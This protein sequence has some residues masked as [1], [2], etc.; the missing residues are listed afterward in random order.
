MIRTKKPSTAVATIKLNDEE[1][2]VVSGGHPG[3]HKFLPPG[4]AKKLWHPTYPFGSRTQ[5]MTNTVTIEVNG[6][7][8]QVGVQITGTQ[9]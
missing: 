9:S 3:P 7:G 6:D 8:N 1:L 2:T 5:T 4:L